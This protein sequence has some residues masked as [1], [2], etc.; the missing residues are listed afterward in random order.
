MICKKIIAVLAIGCTLLAGLPAVSDADEQIVIAAHDLR[1]AFADN[2]NAAEAQYTGKTVL[3][4]GIVVSTGMSKYMTPNV[5][6]SD[7]EGGTV[8]AICVL[9]RLDVGK[10]S[11]F[12]PAQ[13]V[14]MSGRVYRLSERGV[15]LK[16]CKAVE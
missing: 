10:L 7:H 16:E 5:T 12:K 8:H 4:K 13:S 1:K 11:D 6:L 14:T 3:V 9:P 15:V 2:Q